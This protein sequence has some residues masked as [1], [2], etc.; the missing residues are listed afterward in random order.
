MAHRFS[1]TAYNFQK[2]FRQEIKMTVQRIGR[3]IFALVLLLIAV[4]GIS[5]QE[6]AEP[7]P[8]LFKFESDN[9]VMYFFGSIHLGSPDLYPLDDKIL[10]A[11]G[12]SDNLVVELN[13]LESD[14]AELVALF[15]KY[16]MYGKGD[17]LSNHLSAAY[18][19]KL[20]AV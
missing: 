18:V 7:R 11:F 14:T 12:A 8:A 10:A 5:A 6:G 16:L 1:R 13:I 19:E 3:R 4:S 17:S 20:K 2:R 15:Q 9:T